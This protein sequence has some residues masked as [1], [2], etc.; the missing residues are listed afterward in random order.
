MTA[1]SADVAALAADLAAASGTSI[2]A[3]A[4]RIVREVAGELRDQAM[5]YAPVKTGA[6]RDSIEIKFDGPVSATVAPTVPYG[7][8]QEF[9]TGTRGEFP[10]GMYVIRPKKPGG[11]L[12]FKVDGKTVFAKEVK[13]PGV[14]PK[15]YMRRA[16]EKVLAPF[17]EKLAKAGALL[18]TKG[19]NG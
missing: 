4:A 11:S 2:D 10:T 14:K 3:A 15:R 16:T 9:G 12:V 6:L 7:P 13:H 8:H 17:A 18:I 5:A 1:A 19:P